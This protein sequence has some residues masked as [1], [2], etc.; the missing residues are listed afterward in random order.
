MISQPN[1]SI[2]LPRIGIVI[3][4]CDEAPCIGRVLGELLGAIDPRRYA[5]AV[6]VNGS[7]DSTAEIAREFPVLVAETGARG[8]G[9]GCLAAT[10]ALRRELPSI[11]AYLFFAADGAS[12]PRDID[13]LAAAYERGSD[14]VL[15][16]RT[17]LHSN[18]AAMTLPHVLANFAL[19]T[20][21]TVLSGRWFS[22]L[23][24][25]RLIDRRLFEAMD[26]RELTYGWTI[27]AQI[28][29]PRLGAR[30]ARVPVR[31]RARI[32]GEQKVSRVSWRR[33]WSIGWR[34]LAAGWRSHMR[35]ARPIET[36]PR[37]S[38]PELLQPP[39]P[40]S[41]AL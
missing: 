14:F 30:I 12:D 29:A 39:Q 41:S 33:T 32:A 15:G 27:E 23:G 28:A 8:Y 38:A 18:W 9:H 24:P 22:D 10:Q 35:F 2:E 36:A 26:L 16:T 20:W 13:L 6:G 37:P 19:G 25:L 40:R 21:C 4:A 5:V 34:I 7:S 31:E 17:S 3:P 11:D 1:E